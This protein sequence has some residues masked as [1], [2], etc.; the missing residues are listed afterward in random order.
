[1]NDY[2]ATLKLLLRDLRG[3]AVEYLT[4]HKVT[5]W[6]NAELPNVG[7]LEADL[8]CSDEDGA[9][10]HIELQSSN[11]SAM[12]FRMYHYGGRICENYG[13]YPWQILLYVGEARMSMSERIVGPKLDYSFTALD[14]RELDGSPLLESDVLGDNIFAVLLRLRD[15]RSA[16]RQ[17]LK[18][19]GESESGRLESLA[20]LTVLAGLRRLG[21]IVEEESRKMPVTE[22]LLDHDLLGPI[23]RKGIAVGRQEGRDEGLKQGLDRGLKQGL[24][25]GIKQGLDQ[26]LKQGLDK[27]VKQGRQAE[28]V[29]MLRR[30][31]IG[32]FGHVPSTVQER[33]E[34]RTVR[35]LE[36]LVDRALRVE[37][38][39][40]LF[41]QT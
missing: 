2:D 41:P 20:Q 14:V 7:S 34:S 16:V 36:D 22:S 30:I 8:V 13:A 18:R 28:A 17:V 5:Q 39:G 26:G 33:L 12:R 40:D 38:L 9:T 6:H 15:Q 29:A 23:L 21:G 37:T 11:D 31:L 24:D 25:Q 4:G 10:G 19:I 3:R 27:G 32:R 35:Q 1:M